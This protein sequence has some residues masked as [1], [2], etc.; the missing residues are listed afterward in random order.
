MTDGGGGIKQKK[1]LHTFMML[2]MQI[3]V[4]S[5]NINLCPSIFMFYMNF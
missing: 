4:M 2:E 1:H 5:V 3:S